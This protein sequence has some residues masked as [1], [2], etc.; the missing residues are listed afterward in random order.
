MKSFIT[1]FLAF[2][3]AILVVRLVEGHQLN[4]VSF[5]IALGGGLIAACLFDGLML[6]FQRLFHWLGRYYAKRDEQA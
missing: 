3:A 1:S 2:S 4:A 6:I 5:G